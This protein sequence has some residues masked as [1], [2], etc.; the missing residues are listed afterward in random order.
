MVEDEMKLPERYLIGCIFNKL[1]ADWTH[2][3]TDIFRKKT[4]VN[5]N[6]L[7]RFIRNKDEAKQRAKHYV[8][9]KQVATAN[10]VSL[11]ESKVDKR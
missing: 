10:V 5:M 3:T 1:P 4:E 2:F 8:I 11:V 7:L 6:D 9:A